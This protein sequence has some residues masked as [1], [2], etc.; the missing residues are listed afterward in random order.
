VNYFDEKEKIEK[1]AK[2]ISLK[3]LNMKA[4][5][6]IVLV[7]L[8]HFNNVEKSSQDVTRIYSFFD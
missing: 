3:A 1:K 6:V 8:I 4:V 5:L 2:Y 7:L